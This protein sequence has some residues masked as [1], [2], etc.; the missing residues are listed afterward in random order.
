[1]ITLLRNCCKNMTIN[2]TFVIYHTILKMEEHMKSKYVKI[3]RWIAGMIA[4]VLTLSGIQMDC[5]K[6]KASVSKMVT[7]Y[8]VDNTVEHWVKND[9]AVM[10]LVDNTNGHDHYLM[11]TQDCITWSVSVPDTAYNITFNRYNS[12]KTTQWNSW[13]AG[14][15]DKNNAYFADGSEYGHWESI[16]DTSENCFQ[17]GDIVFLDV[18]EFTAWESSNA[19]MY[20]NFSDASKSENGGKDIKISTADKKL[21][22]PSLVDKKVTE[23]IYAYIV[24]K[25]DA[26]K[27]ELRF[28]RG[29]SDNLW[30]CSIVL[31][32]ED[33]VNGIDCV[34]VKGWNDTGEKYDGN[35]TIDLE[36]D[37][38]GDGLPD[39]NEIKIGTDKN[40]PDT[41]GD[42]LN[43][44]Y[45]MEYGYSPI[46]PDTDG[47][48]ITDGN[49]DYDKDNLK[50]SEEFIYKTN[51]AKSD[52]DDDGLLDYDE[53]FIYGTNPLKY[54]TD[55]DGVSDG[56]EINI[57]T[58]P[59]SKDTDGDGIEDCE[60]TFTK[61][62]SAS[63]LIP[64][65]D[66]DVY[67]TISVDG[68][69]N[70]LE[71]VEMDTRDWDSLINCNVPGYVGTAYEFTSAGSFENA[72]VTF[73][74]SEDIMSEPDFAPAIY[75]YNEEEQCLE[76]LK[77]QTV[78]GNTVTAQLEHFSSYIVL[79]SREFDEV[80]DN[81]I[82]YY[83]DE[84]M[85]KPLKI[86]FAVDC[87]GSMSGNDPYYLRNTVSNQIIDKMEE[88]DSGFV[89][90]FNGYVNISQG[91]TTN[92][93][94]LKSVIRSSFCSGMTA[95]R[96]ATYT[97]ISQFSVEN[98]A[99]SRN[100]I[101]VLS[102]G[103]DT[104]GGADVNTLVNLAKERNI[105]LYSIGLG[106]S[107]DTQLLTSL[108]EQTGGKYYHASSAMDLEDIYNQIGG[109]TV[110]FKTDSNNDGISDYYTKL[111]CEGKL[112]T[113]TGIKVI[114]CIMDSASNKV[115][116]GYTYEEVQANDD[117]DGD[118]LKNGE[119][120][121][122]AAN[123]LGTYV[124]MKSNPTTKMSDMDSYSDYI[125]VKKYG[126]DVFK[127]NIVI[128]SE[129][130][131]FLNDNSNYY[132]S[133][134][135]EAYDGVSIQSIT[136]WIGTHI[137]GTDYDKK[138]I[139]EDLLIDYFSY[140]NEYSPSGIEGLEIISST[141]SNIGS[142][143]QKLT[144]KGSESMI[145]AS[146]IKEL[147]NKYDELM[148]LYFIMRE[149]KA[150]PQF[151]EDLIAISNQ[152]EKIASEESSLRKIADTKIVIKFN[153]YTKNLKVTNAMKNIG[154]ICNAVTLAKAVGDGCTSYI[155][156]QA[157]MDI[158]QS[159]IN[160]LNAIAEN[161]S[162][163]ALR[164]AADKMIDI[165]EDKYIETIDCFIEEFDDVK[166]ETIKLAISE[167]LVYFCPEAIIATVAFSIADT[168]TGYSDTSLKAVR[169]YEAGYIPKLI[170][171]DLINL[172]NEHSSD[173]KIY[174]SNS[175]E[176]YDTY[177]D[178]I[179]FRIFAE[180]EMIK[181]ESSGSKW[182]NK[183]WDTIGIG[184]GSN[185]QEIIEDCKN[186]I[187][188]L[189]GMQSRVK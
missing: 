130:I 120:I 5:F 154:K 69:I 133:L 117:L 35:Y 107:I 68:K 102:D 128:S 74:I 2:K 189:S 32:W 150:V 136:S 45:E 186:M 75:Y 56:D 16:E 177:V 13:S 147:N 187:N 160:M 36:I 89:I 17:A 127:D 161:S 103:Y 34:K 88:K 94:L 99:D 143:V 183:L 137:Y 4:I 70:V 182:L 113:G 67:P 114:D 76:K 112:R 57:G 188:I 132:S 66:E 110:D 58:N 126:T 168:V 6:V 27:T 140:R 156:L 151:D 162:D 165:V 100:I 104:E 80:W 22:N 64:Y 92:K 96:K 181:L 9:G 23:H 60:E 153:T 97:S 72:N 134:Y 29:N 167:A 48:G 24:S 174:Y 172:E 40:N 78:I 79:N 106:S 141:V 51:M 83:T 90:L 7:L 3:K 37:T 131:S 62:Y 1:M 26:G 42:G 14:G 142:V 173:E 179:S 157:N 82:M 63:E 43:D 146:D 11:S 111:L 135:S 115:L 158:M 118:G 85:K 8:F 19:L 180:N 169:T 25:K 28:W 108:A 55:E 139:C 171:E 184:A 31:S 84:E 41:D 38:D 144:E 81:D 50:N 148:D 52:T 121:K 61:E 145:A 20:V 159:N 175:S 18:S 152:I 53:I 166:T 71:S 116:R 77:N 49:E 122:V 86:G 73:T 65:Y 59:L 12:G 149:G 30:N 105:K 47:N 155:T 93:E 164:E 21:Y 54:D 39:Y 170:C 176:A 44:Y 109:E 98:A 87:S 124:I 46:K 10:E 163:K 95:L 119:E 101:V 178:I 33:Y 138:E 129:D 123:S 185:R 125:E 15:R 91:L